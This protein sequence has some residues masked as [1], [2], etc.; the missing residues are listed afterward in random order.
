MIRNG[1]NITPAV[2]AGAGIEG[3]FDGA[4]FTKLTIR[5]NEIDN[6][7]T[8]AVATPV[9]G[10]P[11]GDDILLVYNTSDVAVQQLKIVGNQIRGAQGVGLAL[12]GNLNS[13]VDAQ[14]EANTFTN[15]FEGA[16]EVSTID[17]A[18]FRFVAVNNIM[19]ENNA[20][21]DPGIL[22]NETVTLFSGGGSRL[23]GI[24]HNNVI[25]RNG[26]F[27]T[28][29]PTDVTAIRARSSGTSEIAL[30]VFGNQLNSNGDAGLR[31]DATGT[32][33]IGA[34]VRNN[35]IQNNRGNNGVHV[36]LPAG[37]AGSTFIEL[38]HNQVTHPIRLEN[39]GLGDLIFAN[40]GLNTSPIVPFGPGFIQQDTV[41]NV[42]ALILPLFA[43]P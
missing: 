28:T 6:R 7:A 39:L 11:I 27:Q 5:G 21:T 37:N 22:L 26:I 42:D 30:Q 24:F 20:P 13:I 2:A 14:V 4:S 36:L 43:F 1:G 29:A 17:T 18:L 3:I 38:T 10:Q 40:G 25:S 35:M 34:L 41:A 31:L 32:S 33:I 9:A 12:Q 15:N 19:V 16:V 23:I 8:L